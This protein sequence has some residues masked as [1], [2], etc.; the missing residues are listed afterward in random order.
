LNYLLNDGDITHSIEKEV[1]EANKDK[2]N[3]AKTVGMYSVDTLVNR[4]MSCR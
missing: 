3:A 1:L 4:I 2:D